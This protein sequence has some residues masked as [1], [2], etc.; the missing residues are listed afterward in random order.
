[1][2]LVT[3]VVLICVVVLN[4]HF[5]TPSTHVLTEDVKKVR[6]LKSCQSPASREGAKGCRGS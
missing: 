4:I 5:R 6:M 3:M 1:M 2:V